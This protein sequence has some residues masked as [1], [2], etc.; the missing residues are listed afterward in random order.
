MGEGGRVRKW[1][2]GE[3]QNEGFMGRRDPTWLLFS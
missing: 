3:G 2:G 1:G